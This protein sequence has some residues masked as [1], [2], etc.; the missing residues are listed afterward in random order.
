MRNVLSVDVEDYFHV[1]AFASQISCDQW[2][3]FQCRVE[4]NVARILELLDVYKAK[5]TF[6]IL[7]WVAEKFPCLVRTI[8][9]EG[10]EIG[11]HSYAHRRLHRLTPDEFREDLRRATALLADQVQRPIESY[12]APSFS[13]VDSTMWA[14]DVLI[15]E[16]YRFDSSIFPVRHDF[17][18][19]PDAER[20]PHWE[21][22]ASGRI[23]EFPPSTVGY[24]DKTNLG[25]GG[26]G[27]LRLFPY[28]LTHWAFRHINGVES[29]PAMVYLHPWEIDPGQPGIRAGFRSTVRH[30][31]NLSTMEGKLERLLQDFAFTTLVDAC[32]QHQAYRVG[33]AAPSEHL[34]ASAKD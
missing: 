14:V 12:R 21:V 25:V 29:Q 27:Y 15:N 19:V 16:G 31:T 24:N 10:H 7:G 34:L 9:G 30:Y 33:H 3:S 4:K 32:T 23:F 18:G 20:F 5:G 2:D 11:C 28:G 1:E 6:F 8:A 26:G 13:I 22:S 17:Y